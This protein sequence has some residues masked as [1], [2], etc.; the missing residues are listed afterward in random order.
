MTAPAASTPREFG[1]AIGH[2]LKAQP[3]PPETASFLA[4]RLMAGVP[5]ARSKTDGRTEGDA[6]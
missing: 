1:A 2:R 4:S 6:A 3:I 5:Q